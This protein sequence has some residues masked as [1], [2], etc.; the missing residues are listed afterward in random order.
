MPHLGFDYEDNAETRTEYAH[1]FEEYGL[2]ANPNTRIPD[3]VG[4]L[5]TRQL[6]DLLAAMQNL[7]IVSIPGL[8]ETIP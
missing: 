2:L 1:T 5:S 7:G 3:R 4:K 8:F 6:R